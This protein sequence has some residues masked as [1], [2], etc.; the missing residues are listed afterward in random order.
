[1]RAPEIQSRISLQNILFATDFSPFSDYALPYAVALA[2]QY[3]GAIFATHVAASAGNDF[4]TSE[5]WPMAID[6]IEH[7]DQEQVKRLDSALYGVPH[8]IL[9]KMGHVWQVLRTLIREHN[10]D[11]LVLGTHGR[12]GFRK[13]MMGSVAEEIFRQAQCPV[14]TVGPEVRSRGDGAIRLRN[15]LFAT[16]FTL[17]SVAGLRYAISLAEE[18]EG[19]LSMLHCL[20]TPAVGSVDFESHASFLRERLA[21]LVPKDAEFWCRTKCFV[22]YGDHAEAIVNFAA[23]HDIDL[24]VMGVR[25]AAGDPEIATHLASRTAHKVVSHA[26]CPVLTVRG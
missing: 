15:I 7:R 20:E 18:N 24:I 12:T 25:P 2:R 4:V 8:K 16:D 5:T 23:T 9:M 19:T 3:G 21:D 10:I 14:L 17:A 26:T 13:L 22:E 11:L 1:M 6:D